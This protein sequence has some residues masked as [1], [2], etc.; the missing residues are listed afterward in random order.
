V[1]SLGEIKTKSAPGVSALKLN[2]KTLKSRARTTM[3]ACEAVRAP[4]YVTCLTCFRYATQPDWRGEAYCSATHCCALTVARGV[5][6]C[7]PCVH[8]SA[9]TQ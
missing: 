1:D 2:P 4:A 7:V 9:C 3:G 6:S 8:R 5:M